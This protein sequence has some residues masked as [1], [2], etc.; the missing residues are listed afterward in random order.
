MKTTNIIH[1]PSALICVICGLTLLPF[2][3]MAEV[4]TSG[5]VVE[6]G[7]SY[8]DT[9]TDAALRVIGS[10]VLYTGTDITLTATNDSISTGTAGRGAYVQNQAAL[11]LTG[12]TVSTTGSY[13]Y[14]IYLYDNSSGTINNVN[15]ETKGLYSFGA[16]AYSSSTLTLVGGTIATTGTDAYG[17]YLSQASTGTVSNVNIIT[18]YAYGVR[19]H[20]SSTLTL[21]G[22]TITVTDGVERHGIFITATSSGT[23]NGVNVKTEGQSGHGV[24]A[25]DSST[26]ALTDSDISTSGSGAY[27]LLIHNRSTGTASLNHNT[28]TGNISATGTSTLTLSGSNGTVI[29]GDVVADSGATVGITL[30]GK[31]TALHGNFDRR[32]TSV[33]NL[34][35]GSDALLDGS[36]TL[37]SLTL[38]N[39]AVIGYTGLITVTDSIT[40]DGTVTIDLSKLTETGEYEI[41]DWSGAGAADVDGA[42]YNFTGAEGDFTVQGDKLVFNATAV[43][44]PSTW[45]LLGAGLSTLLLTVRRNAQ[46]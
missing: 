15:I 43:P 35:V 20:L 8:H 38:E 1:Q 3:T 12:G 14:G 45:F 10:G 32:G 21:T 23:V 16:H 24:F 29:T 4:I 40:I 19:A 5:T 44:E 27:A 34:T 6:T 2:N 17:I 25:Y 37:D 26:L 33:I 41:I 42:N 46:S 11:S 39:G 31:G 9:A 30:A 13:G 7:S 36:G 18:K 22:G 28:I